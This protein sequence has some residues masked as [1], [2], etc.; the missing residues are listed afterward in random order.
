MTFIARWTFAFLLL[1]VTFNPTQWNYVAWARREYESSLSL[2][3]L[4]GL[5][6]VIAYVVY[7]R[8]TFRSIGVFGM[9]LVAAL[10]TVLG[11][12]LHDFG[13]LSFQDPDLNVWLSIL[14]ISLVLGIGMS[15][16]FVRRAL[17]GQLDVDDVDE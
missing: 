16:S 13:L 6:L 12:V 9:L 8:A 4:F 1:A 10:V 14:A 17:S 5:I 3:I 11:W 7:L 15:W 2:V